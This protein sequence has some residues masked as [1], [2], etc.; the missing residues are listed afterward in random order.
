MTTAEGDIVTLLAENWTLNDTLDKWRFKICSDI[1]FHGGCPLTAE[2]VAA[3]L[4]K[5]KD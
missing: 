5:F 3:K 2:T 1:T 4:T